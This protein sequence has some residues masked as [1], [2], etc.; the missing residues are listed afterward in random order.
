MS[1]S[2]FEYHLLYEYARGTLEAD[3]AARVAEHV[4]SCAECRETVDSLSGLGDGLG[5]L[6]DVTRHDLPE[7]TAHRL[8]LQAAQEL[9]RPG[10]RKR[11]RLSDVRHRPRNVLPRL[12]MPIAAAVM[13]LL[14][15]R[16][17]SPLFEPPQYRALDYLYADAKNVATVTGIHDLQPQALSALDEAIASTNP[18]ALRVANLQLIHYITL[19]AAEPDQ[20]QDVHFLLGLLKE[21]DRLR[22]SATATTAPQATASLWQTSAMAAPSSPAQHAA[23]L[24][25]QGRYDEAYRSLAGNDDPE[26]QALVA[27]AALRSLRLPEAHES[28][29]AL[30]TLGGPEHAIAPLLEAE[31]A[32]MENRFDKATDYFAAAANEIDNR[33]WF[34][35]GYLCKYEIGDDTLAGQYFERTADAEVV[36]H[37]SVRFHEDVVVARQEMAL[38]QEDYES[39][40]T[41][42]LPA[43]WKLVPTHPDEFMIAEFDGSRALKQNEMGHRGGKLVAGFPGWHDYVMSCDFK[44]LQAE[45]D[46]QLDFVVYDLGK[47]HY[48][49]EFSDRAA[50]LQIKTRQEAE[51]V[52]HRPESAQLRLPTPLR[53]GDWWRL[54]IQV[55][56]V[57]DGTT[58]ITATVAL[59]DRPD[60]PAQSFTWTDQ[61]GADQSPQR[62][63]RVGF[64][65]GGA[66][67]AFDNL[68]VHADEHE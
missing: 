40:A 8:L 31:L 47:S 45:F 61:A 25:C 20:I 36:T 51:A 48:A 55:R 66:E 17:V 19:R 43:A 42:P 12:L 6:E 18:N 52:I 68:V 53:A 35:A 34:Q 14:G 10:G 54:S 37:V 13:V 16:L 32:M 65:V 41:G 23:D 30:K 5:R 28:I 46:P 50:R 22:P 60:Q 9:Y 7:G 67:V 21:D 64:R 62:R 56:N 63:G 59:R 29:E 49:V 33:L 11:L 26:V 1:C 4:A 57:D 39:Y 58:R 24:I 3:E 2:Q 27:Y 44:V 38:M 15:L